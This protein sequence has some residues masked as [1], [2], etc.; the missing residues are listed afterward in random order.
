MSRI[1]EWSS[2]IKSE[3]KKIIWP[4]KK[5]T[6]QKT[7]IVL[8]IAVVLGTILVMLDTIFQNLVNVIVGLF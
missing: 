7:S 3:W 8:I 2:G 5:E 6:A 4:N 1:K